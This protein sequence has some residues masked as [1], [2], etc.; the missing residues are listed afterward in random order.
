MGSKL[1]LLVLLPFYTKW[2]SVEQYGVTD[3]VTVYV[4]LL[5]GVVTFS[6]DA[7][8]FVFPKGKS[9]LEQKTFFSTGIFFSLFSIV[10]LAIVFFII[11]FFSSSSSFSNTFVD[12]IWFIFIMLVSQVSLQTIQQFC[13]SIDKMVIYSLTGFLCTIFIAIF[14]F[15]LVPNYGVSGYVFSITLSNLMAS[16]FSFY[17]SGSYRYLSF[18]FYDYSVLKSMLK[19]TIPIIPNGVMW[20]IVNALNRPL[21]ESNLGLHSLGIYAVANKFPSILSMIFT[22]FLTS[23]QISVL[24]EFGKNDFH[25]F[26]NKIFR[27]ITILLLLV[28]LSI[29]F[30]SKLLVSCFADAEFIEAWKYIPFLTFGVFFS[31]ISG[32]LGAVFSATKESKYLLY[33]TLGGAAVAVFLN[34]LLIP[35]YGLFGSA[36]S[37]ILSFIVV[38]VI[39]SYFSWKYSP[40]YRLGFLIVYVVSSFGIS[41]MV[42]YEY[43]T[44]HIILTTILFLLVMLWLERD[45]LANVLL[46]LGKKFKFL[47]KS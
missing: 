9:L 34:F 24:E 14:A 41:L 11:D 4:T 10:F 47:K 25:L 6:I 33:S 16:L 36:L 44:L 7:A 38:S 37:I 8:L 28:L 19:Y 39:R 46:L 20:W 15:I 12:N 40:I 45:S 23:W 26:F 30:C 42:V 17:A 29:V 32:F 22:V 13:R 21:L 18:N 31:N 1:I 2:L 5:L 3:I 43:D 27:G 35:F